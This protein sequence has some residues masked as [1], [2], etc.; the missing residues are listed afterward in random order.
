MTGE[1]WTFGTNPRMTKM[2]RDDR[3]KVDPRDEPKDD[4]KVEKLKVDLRDEPKGDRWG[5]MAE[6]VMTG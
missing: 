4:R 1:R 6:R 3:L 2:R 5:A